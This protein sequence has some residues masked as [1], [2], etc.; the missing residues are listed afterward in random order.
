MDAWTGTWNELASRLLLL[1]PRLVA[2]LLIF[3]ITLVATGAVTRLV[4][5]ALKRRRATPE[6]TLLL[7]RLARWTTLVF[8]CIVAL[9]QVNFDLTAF[10]AGLGILG[11]TVGFAV[12]DVSKNLVAGVLLLLQQPFDLGDTIQ[13][14]SYTG[15]VV[16]VDLRAT[17]LRGLDGVHVLIPN[18]D[19]YT[20]AIVQYSRALRR[21]IEL[22]VGV[23]NDS[24]LELVKRTAL[25]A[26]AEVEGV[27]PDPGPV[28]LIA[29]LGAS[30]VDL[31]VHYWIDPRVSSLLDAKDAGLRAIVRAF[32]AAGIEMPYPTQTVQ[33]R[34]PAPG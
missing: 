14:G 23:A 34:Y 32:A 29:N 20:S 30:T 13:V 16:T 3:V 6:L 28:V 1:A 5:R 15:T 9:Q 11:F 22:G 17:E 2:A 19:V 18:T 25:D 26:V 27:L 33:V 8:G 12:Q 10:L 21:R 31:T 4:A 7:T 24:D